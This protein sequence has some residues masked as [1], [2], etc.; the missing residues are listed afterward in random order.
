MANFLANARRNR[1]NTNPISVGDSYSMPLNAKVYSPTPSPL[2]G[3][4]NFGSGSVLSSAPQTNAVAPVTNNKPDIGGT[5]AGGELYAPKPNPVTIAIG[6]PA[7]LTYADHGLVESQQIQLKTTGAL[8]TGLTAYTKYY[9]TQPT[10]NTFLLIFNSNL[11]GTSG[12]Q[13]GVHSLLTKTI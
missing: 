8:P 12:T 4:T 1:M 10:A 3:T 13:S 7:V 5:S 6:S 9:V 11:V 2:P